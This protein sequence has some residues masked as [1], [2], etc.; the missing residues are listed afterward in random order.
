MSLRR[1]RILVEH[2]PEES[3]TVRHRVGHRWSVTQLLL[4]D[5]L[6]VLRYYRC[7]WLMA[8]GAHPDKPEPLPRPGITDRQTRRDAVRAAHDQVMSQIHKGA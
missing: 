1:L 7:E 8:H 6:D 4:A 5:V 3:A 2:L